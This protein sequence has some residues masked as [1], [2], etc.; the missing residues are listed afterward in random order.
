MILLPITSLSW[1]VD[2]SA[3]NGKVDFNQLK[4]LG[5]SFVIIRDGLGWGTAK[6]KDSMLDA[7]Y[8][9]AKQAGMLVGF[10]HFIWED[11]IE[12][13]HNEAIQCIKNIKD[14]HVDLFVA[15]DI[16]RSEHVK[17]SADVLQDMI[18][19][20]SVDISIVSYRP[21][22]YTMGSLMR[23]LNWSSLPLELIPWVANW[24]G[25]PTPYMERNVFLWQSDV[26][27]TTK[28]STLK[29]QLPG[30][31]NAIDINRWC[32]PE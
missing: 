22:I 29:V 17:L 9:A 3:N 8:D 19:Q 24:S 28:E 25:N 13:I 27:G 20:W 31:Q 26:A 6:G 21:A 16:E 18:S 10:Y 11:S 7:H 32:F 1:G 4:R 15:A 14:K 5:C 30:V 23:R 12:G 2:V